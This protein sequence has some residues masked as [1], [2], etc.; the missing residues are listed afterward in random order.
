MSRATPLARDGYAHFHAITT[1][2]SDNDAYGHVNNVVYYNWFDT[3]VNAFLVRHGQ[4]DIVQGAVI[5][6][7]IE[8]GCTY[9]SAVAFPDA[10]TAGLRVTSLGTSSVRYE[11]GIFRGDATEPSA[12]GHFVHVCVDRANRQPIPIPAPLRLL[13]QSLVPAT[14]RTPADTPALAGASHFT[15]PPLPTG[16]TAT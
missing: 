6:L 10:V 13:L 15:S 8:T 1:R 16:D 7:V 12:Q 14:D 11:V 2:W 3:I 9:F 4:L 5:C